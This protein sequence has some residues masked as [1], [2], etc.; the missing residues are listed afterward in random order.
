MKKN[1]IFMLEK[2]R[3]I[4]LKALNNIFATVPLNFLQQY[5]R[6]SLVWFVGKKIPISTRLYS[7]VATLNWYQT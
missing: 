4:F 1:N 3:H 7:A 6:A 5:S 2:T